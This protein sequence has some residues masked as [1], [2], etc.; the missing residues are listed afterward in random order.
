VKGSVTRLIVRARAQCARGNIFMRCA[1][2]LSPSLCDLR[3][4]NAHNLKQD[5]LFINVRRRIRLRR[6]WISIAPTNNGTQRQRRDESE[7]VWESHCCFF[8][9][10]LSAV[11]SLALCIKNTLF[12]GAHYVITARALSAYLHSTKSNWGILDARTLRLPAY[13]NT[14]T[15]VLQ[16]RGSKFNFHC[17]I[18]FCMLIIE[19][20]PL[21]A[22]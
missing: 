15:H 18:L 21:H 8:F 5:N 14:L 3:C 12:S 9:L 19:A 17:R 10:V 13:L 2:S 22:I 16:R 11:A 6:H 4:R 7:R 1:L 20:T